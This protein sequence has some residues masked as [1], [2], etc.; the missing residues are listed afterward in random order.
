MKEADG[1][2]SEQT[3]YCEGD[4]SSIITNRYCTVP[5]S[6]LRAEPYLLT[7]GNLVKAKVTAKNERGSGTQSDENEDAKAVAVQTE[8]G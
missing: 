2:F 3:T 7:L 8:P 1:D 5:M 6:V 4:T